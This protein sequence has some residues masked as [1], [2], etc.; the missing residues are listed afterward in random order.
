MMVVVENLTDTVKLG[1][2]RFCLPGPSFIINFI[3]KRLPLEKTS[4]ER[5]K[6]DISDSGESTLFM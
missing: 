2:N 5:Q 6:A 4:H 3:I 1:F